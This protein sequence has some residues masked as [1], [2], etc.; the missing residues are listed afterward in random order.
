MFFDV[1]SDAGL[2]AL[3]T[4][5]LHNSYIKPHT[6]TLTDYDVFRRVGAAP[7]SLRYPNIARWYRHI[8]AQCLTEFADAFSVQLP[9]PARLQWPQ[10]HGYCGEVSVLSGGL[11]FGQ[12]VSQYTARSLASHKPH[13]LYESQLLLEGNDLQAA[14]AMKLRASKFVSLQPLSADDHA[15][16]KEYLVWVR[17]ECGQGHA[18]TIGVFM[19]HYHFYGFTSNLNA[20]EADYDHIV[21]VVGITSRYPLSDTRFHGEDIVHFSDNGIFQS[22][23]R[24]PYMFSM[25]FSELLCT[26]AQ[27][28]AV[29]APVYTVPAAVPNQGIAIHGIQDEFGETIRVQVFTSDNSEPEIEQGCDD[30]P[31]PAPLTLTVR[32]TGLQPGVPYRLYQY[33]TFDAVPTSAFQAHEA[34]AVAKWDVL[35][36][37][38]SEHEQQVQIL[39]S[40]TAVFRAVQVKS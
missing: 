27:A 7:D 13:H 29:Q 3:N 37:Q 21:P 25:S 4:H 12:Y 38:G 1:S 17:Q 16:N 19:N 31:E 35:S 5:L 34:N 22:Y 14:N 24:V 9:I 26:R 39:S 6:L 36:G 30:A 18:V 23:G 15:G 33:D 8:D 20:G 2:Q 32:L 11:H 28:N 10:N 40:Q